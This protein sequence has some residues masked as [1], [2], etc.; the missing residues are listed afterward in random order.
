M[1]TYLASWLRYALLFLGVG[2]ISG[3]IVHFPL[4]PAKNIVLLSVGGGLFVWGTLWNERHTVH[5][6]PMTSAET[7]RLVVLSLLLSIGIGMMSGA[8]QHFDEEP[9]YAAVLI[10]L[11]VVLSFVAYSLRE[12]LTRG[13]KP[14][15]QAVALVAALA[16]GLHVG[17]DRLAE[18]FAGHHVEHE[19]ML[20][21]P[22][23]H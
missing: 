9:E 8:T 19:H 7:V 13:A 18:H 2:L 22:H 5:A 6:H 17:L 1:T 21:G 14:F 4:N 11:G 12:R 15:L 10:P 23:Q 3:A 20:F 16:L